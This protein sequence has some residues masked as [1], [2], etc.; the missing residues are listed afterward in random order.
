MDRLKVVVIERTKQQMPSV[1]FGLPTLL[2]F[3]SAYQRNTR[4]V[5]EI[6]TF[7]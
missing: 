3:S 4:S 2:P 7:P 5:W 6:Q 1:L